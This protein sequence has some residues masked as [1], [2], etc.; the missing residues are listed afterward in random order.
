MDP[1]ELLEIQAEQERQRL[2]ALDSKATVSAVWM[3]DV[4]LDVWF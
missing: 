3:L 1:E 4:C 2:E